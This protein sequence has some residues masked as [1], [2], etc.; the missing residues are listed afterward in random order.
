MVPFSSRAWLSQV[1]PVI[2]VMFGIWESNPME[3]TGILQGCVSLNVFEW[4][5][6]LQCRS[7]C[8]CWDFMGL[9]HKMGAGAAWPGVQGVKL[10]SCGTSAAGR[11]AGATCWHYF[12]HS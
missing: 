6:P 4:L 2:W 1:D 11:A 12:K 7:V 9:K 8:N 5:P 10:L 3:N